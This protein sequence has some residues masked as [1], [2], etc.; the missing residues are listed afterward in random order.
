MVRCCALL[1]VAVRQ[2]LRRPP[3]HHLHTSANSSRVTAVAMV[4]VSADLPAKSKPFARVG[5]R[6]PRRA[7]KRSC[8][9]SGRSDADWWSSVVLACP[10]PGHE[11]AALSS[12]TACRMPHAR[13]SL[14]HPSHP[15]LRKWQCSSPPVHSFNNPPIHI[16]P[17]ARVHFTSPPH[18]LRWPHSAHCCRPQTTRLVRPTNQCRSPRRSSSST[19]T[20]FP[21]TGRARTPSSIPPPHDYLAQQTAVVPTQWLGDPPI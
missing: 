1:C 9:R 3:S 20:L 2:T 15:I 5:V 14:Q 17:P 19:P 13:L 4:K 7:R 10:A 18:V 21:I 6:I 8:S 11:Q 12:T 16:H